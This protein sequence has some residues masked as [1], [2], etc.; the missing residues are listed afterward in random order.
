M[1]QS[2]ATLASHTHHTKAI[3]ARD[4]LSPQGPGRQERIPSSWKR[5]VFSMLPAKHN[6]QDGRGPS[7][8]Q[9]PN[10][11]ADPLPAHFRQHLGR[12]G[13]PLQRWP[14]HEL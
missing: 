9:R 12:A 5:L 7:A 3:K 2:K 4:E 14:T 6:L 1:A 8:L 11:P 10:V 13:R